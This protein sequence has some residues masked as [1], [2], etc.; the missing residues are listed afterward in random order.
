MRLSNSCPRL[1]VLILPL[2]LAGCGYNPFQ[3]DGRQE[4]EKL[5]VRADGSMQFRGRPI[6]TEDVV[7]YRDGNGGEKAAVRVRMEPLHPDYFR[8]TIIV[9]RRSDAKD[10]DRALT[11]N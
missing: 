2:L 3:D 7:I 1:S 4:P 6:G 5:V 9:E 11:Q 8:D 10:E